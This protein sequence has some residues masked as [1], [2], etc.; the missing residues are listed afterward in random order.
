MLKLIPIGK[1]DSGIL[2]SIKELEDF[3][4]LAINLLPNESFSKADGYIDALWEYMQEKKYTDKELFIQYDK[5]IHAYHGNAIL[6]T[7][8][9][10]LLMEKDMRD[11]GLNDI[12]VTKYNNTQRYYLNLIRNLEE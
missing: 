4:Y 5:L 3:A 1:N 9:E 6:K 10:L 2:M 11:S 12:I 7:I 8:I